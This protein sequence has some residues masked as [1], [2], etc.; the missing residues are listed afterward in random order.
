M[1]RTHTFTHNPCYSHVGSM[2]GC[3]GRGDR[4]GPEA[5]AAEAEATEPAG[6]LAGAP[7]RALAPAAEQWE[8]ADI[9]FAPTPM[10]RWANNA[11]EG[12]PP[13]WLSWTSP[14]GAGWR[15]GDLWGH[16]R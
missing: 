13:W 8:R 3:I 4:P 16:D 12:Y 1:G 14:P 2:G 11:P 15:G 6:A 10:R 7:A 9:K 5:A